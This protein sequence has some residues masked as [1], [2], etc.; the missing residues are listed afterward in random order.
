MFKLPHEIQELILS[1]YNPYEIYYKNKYNEILPHIL[2][3]KLKIP[4]IYYKYFTF[5]KY[6]WNINIIWS[7]TCN[8]TEHFK[9]AGY[10]TNRAIL[11]KINEHFKHQH[12]NK[13]NYYK[14]EYEI[15]KS[16][17][18]RLKLFLHRGD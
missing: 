17:Y 9:I 4:K 10:K 16:H 14:K 6:Y 15:Y 3:I 12:N 18:D 8:C 7:M 1:F 11:K 5:N 13:I 2:A